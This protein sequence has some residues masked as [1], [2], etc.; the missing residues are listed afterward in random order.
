MVL[1]ESTETMSEQKEDT[2]P[3]SANVRVVSYNILSSELA[4]PEFFTKCD[5][6]HLSAKARLPKILDKLQEEIDASSE[7]SPVVFCLQEV[8]HE[9]ATGLHIFFAERGYHLV[10]GLYGKK[11]NG[12]M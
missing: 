5:R 8:S 6:Q 11:F 10:T 1:P 12:Y 7:E 9:W 3:Q 4:D 2:Q